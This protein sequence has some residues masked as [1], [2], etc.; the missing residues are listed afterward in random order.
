MEE[1]DIKE[2]SEMRGMDLQSF[3]LLAVEDKLARERASVS[4]DKE[5]KEVRNK[6][7]LVFEPALQMLK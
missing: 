5:R 6:M 4:S 1:I 3:G 2:S 7:R